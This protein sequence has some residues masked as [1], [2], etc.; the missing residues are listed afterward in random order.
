MSN[1]FVEF[2]EKLS[3]RDKSDFRNR[4]PFEN[5]DLNPFLTP[6]SDQVSCLE[7]TRNLKGSLHKPLT[8]TENT[9]QQEETHPITRSNAGDSL[10][11]RL[12]SFQSTNYHSSEREANC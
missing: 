6:E 4:N 5:D 9:S 3:P 1:P 10:E 8:T 7:Q 11:A 12:Y 2:I